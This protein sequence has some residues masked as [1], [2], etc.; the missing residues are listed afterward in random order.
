MTQCGPERP[1]HITDSMPT[2]ATV[3]RHMTAYLDD[4]G[5]TV[6]DYFT[7]TNDYFAFALAE[8]GLSDEEEM[9]LSDRLFGAFALLPEDASA[10][11]VT[12]TIVACIHAFLPDTHKFPF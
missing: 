1:P 3:R 9:I 10:L 8:A 5:L 6:T 12:A 11:D 7:D 2:H 4:F